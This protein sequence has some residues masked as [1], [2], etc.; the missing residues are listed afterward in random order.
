MR[1][2]KTS[3][4]NKVFVSFARGDLLVENL[5]VLVKAEGIKSALITAGIGTFDICRIHWIGHTG[6]PP[7]NEFADLEGPLE[8][9]SMLGNVVD[10]V[11]HVHVAMADLQRT[12][13]G[14]LEHGS[15]VCYRAELC[16]EILPGLDLTTR[17]N[18]ETNLLEIVGK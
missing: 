15:R 16:L 3:E 12:Y 6:L 10:G 18:P 9:A 4:G 11:V 14:H 17:R 7:T 8:V 13:I 2:F 1:Y 5:E